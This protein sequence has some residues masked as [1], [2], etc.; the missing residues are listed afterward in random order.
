MQTLWR[1]HRNGENQMKISVG[2]PEGTP[3]PPKNVYMVEFTGMHGDADHYS[4][5]AVGPFVPGKDNTALE[6]LLTLLH[7]MV[8]KYPNGR[9]GGEEYGFESVPGFLG[10]FNE[11]DLWDEEFFRKIE[12]RYDGKVEFASYESYVEA[13]KLA[14]QIGWE[15]MWPSDITLQD[16]WDTHNQVDPQDIKVIYYNPQGERHNVEYSL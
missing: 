1:K 8:E 15:E 7:A 4:K 6:S 16:M 2:A 14:K 10:W 11:G 9:G 3:E 12:A 5:H 13:W